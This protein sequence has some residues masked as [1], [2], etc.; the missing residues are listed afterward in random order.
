MQPSSAKRCS[1]DYKPDLSGESED[2]RLI[3]ATIWPQTPEPEAL[4][5]IDLVAV[6]GF[7]GGSTSTWRHKNGTSLLSDLLPQDFPNCRI[8]AFGYNIEGVYYVLDEDDSF[9]AHGR[10]L[11]FAEQL[12][13]DLLDGRKQRDRPI[14]FMCHGVGGI[15]VKNA[16]IYA[17]MKES[18]YGS[19]LD[20]TCHIIFLDTPHKGFD[21]EAWSAISGEHIAQTGHD[22][23]GSWSPV[24]S[25]LDRYFAEIGSNFSI[26]S[27]FASHSTISIVGQTRVVQETS[28][29]LGFKNETSVI[30]DET[31]HSTI[32]KFASAD[33]PG[34]R[35]LRARLESVLSSQSSMSKALVC[36]GSWVM[37]RSS[38]ISSTMISHIHGLFKTSA[39]KIE[40]D[41]ESLK[42]LDWISTYDHESNHRRLSKLRQPDTGVWILG[43]PEFVKWLDEERSSCLWCHGILGAG[44]TIMTT[45]VVEA[46]KRRS[47]ITGVAV[48]YVYCRYD[49]QETLSAST[50][51]ASFIKQLLFY[52]E[53]V[54][55][56]CPSLIREQLA[57]GYRQCRAMLD[58]DQATEILLCLNS[59][60]SEVIY[61]IDGLD[62]CNSN[63]ATRVLRFVKKAL[64]ASSA[65]RILRV[66]ISSTKEVDVPRLVPST[67]H[68]ALSLKTTSR[69]I[70]SYV[71]K[72]I[73]ERNAEVELT[74][75][76][77]LLQDVKRKLIEGAQGMFLWVGFQVDALWEYCN[78]DDE[79]QRVLETLPEGMH[80][81][82]LR[83]LLR[84]DRRKGDTKL[85]PSVLK[86][87]GSATRALHIDE[88]KEA[89]AF[90]PEDK[91]WEASK[92]PN[93]DSLIIRCCAGLVV[94]DSSDNSVRFAH[95]SVKQFI[96]SETRSDSLEIY[97]FSQKQAELEVGEVCVAYLSFSEFGLQLTEKARITLS[98]DIHSP[99]ESLTTLALSTT[100]VSSFSKICF[101]RTTKHRNNIRMEIPKRRPVAAPDAERYKLLRYATANWA[102]HTRSIS[103]Q[104]TVWD[105]FRLLALQPNESWKIHPWN[106]NQYSHHSHLKG[107]FG[108]AVKARH[109]PLL[110]VVLGLP[111]EYGFRDFCNA[112]LDDGAPALHIASSLGYVDVAELLLTACGINTLDLDM[113]T[114]L[115]YAAGT[116]QLA[117]AG[118]L[119]VTKGVKVD[120]RSSLQQTPLWLAAAS[121]NSQ[122]VRLLIKR[123]VS[124]DSRDHKGMTPFDI[125]A[126]NGHAEVLKI[127][128]MEGQ[129]KDALGEPPLWLAVANG[130]AMVVG[131][132]LELGLVDEDKDNSLKSNLLACAMENGHGTVVAILLER[133]GV[134][135]P[136][137]SDEVPAW[138]ARNGHMAVVKLLL[139]RDEIDQHFKL[140]ESQTLLSWAV[141]NE[142][143]A[144]L[145]LFLEKRDHTVT[146]IVERECKYLDDLEELRQVELFLESEFLSIDHN[147]LSIST[148][149][150]IQF[151]SNHDALSN[152]QRRFLSQMEAEISKTSVSQRW[153]SLFVLHED[154]FRIYEHYV[155]TMQHVQAMEELCSIEYRMALNLTSARLFKPLQHLAEY[156]SLLKKLLSTLTPCQVNVTAD[157]KLGIL[158]V[159]SVLKRVQAAIHEERR[160]IAMTNLLDPVEDWNPHN[161]A[162]LGDLILYGQFTVDKAEDT[163]EMKREY[164]LYLFESRLLW[165]EDLNK[166]TRQKSILGSSRSAMNIKPKVSTEFQLLYAPALLERRAECRT[167]HHPFSNGANNEGMPTA[168]VTYLDNSI[169]L[170]VGLSASYD[171]LAGDI[172]TK[173]LR[174]L[175][176]SLVSNTVRLRYK[177]EDGDYITIDSD[178]DLQMALAPWHET[179]PKEAPDQQFV[180]I[181]LHIHDRLGFAS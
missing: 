17:K 65:Q 172:D 9:R 155:R 62:E 135:P 80:E 27:F 122:L 25:D 164:D 115:H 71:E 87:V 118:L 121:G 130:H 40:T 124:L 14:I 92:I 31:S 13:N 69:D 34:Y 5:A 35:R 66:F 128:L 101:P 28:S 129:V 72:I 176:S 86:W 98:Q 175:G 10:V 89:I 153:G 93:N 171:S 170:D 136:M 160:K 11:T 59:G 137:M 46:A 117:V 168:R 78:N 84:I 44:K 113:K 74:K 70:R 167:F 2:D 96:F 16:L 68:I 76:L 50:L 120:L 147:F 81:T 61:V 75:D 169:I 145:N 30:L 85:A 3:L 41:E 90:S 179:P 108:W 23:F 154:A 181:N 97:R 123:H 159:E 111:Q 36:R 49:Q 156:P 19:I 138:A 178:E 32:C 152:F 148:T 144:L 158:M 51:L 45:A 104:S 114:A 1:H 21:R 33:T 157:L 106:L 12:C 6:H 60:I 8:M 119:L 139:T 22:Q 140:D 165:L 103:S 26:T 141:Q 174:P 105:M 163:C 54:R 107:L 20:S 39:S 55:T 57:Q 48:L 18:M 109:I 99:V 173:L 7:A 102:P 67:A 73:T 112:I 127:L 142:H 88:L 150:S 177:D 162:T 63:E 125:A 151:R 38:K 100:L 37:E 110:R 79:I 43:N 91:N 58:L 180:V 64:D 116:D 4:T 133:Y 82:Y 24:L 53:V 77:L 149:M 56:P 143:T 52:L 126:K 83:C 161:L 29:V 94:F 15:V 132:L 47:P 146:A 166:D 134:T 42:L 95:H 131:M